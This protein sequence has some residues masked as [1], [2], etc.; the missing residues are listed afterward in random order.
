VAISF[1][2]PLA[3]ARRA[4]GHPA[5]AQ[6]GTTA[7]LARLAV[8][9]HLGRNLGRI[10]HAA[11]FSFGAGTFDLPSDLLLDAAPFLVA[12]LVVNKPLKLSPPHIEFKRAHLYD[13][14]PV[15]V[16]AMLLAST[17]AIIAFSGSLGTM[18]Q[19]L[20]PFVA[21]AT[22]FRLQLLAPVGLG[23]VVP[24]AE[25]FHDRLHGVGECLVGLV[26]IHPH[27]VSAALR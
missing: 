27:G 15:G 8:I 21:L 24:G 9:E 14:N 12:D 18:L 2:D 3:F 17:L 10:G 16:G 11:L 22:A 19:H 1:V 25:V 20:A 7:D 5:E 6:S 26:E 13:F 23:H 4:V